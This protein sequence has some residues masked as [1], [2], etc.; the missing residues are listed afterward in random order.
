MIKFASIEHLA[1]EALSIGAKHG[2]T[3]HAL[4]L[5]R[6]L[7]TAHATPP[8]EPTVLDMANS[9]VTVGTAS[10]TFPNADVIANAVTDVEAVVGTGIEIAKIV[11]G[12]KKG[13]N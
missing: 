13:A 2:F 12:S 11:K 10:I 4:N 8:A 5:V 7:L 6:D 3:T 9:T 1:T